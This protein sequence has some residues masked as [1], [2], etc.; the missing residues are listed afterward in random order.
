MCIVRVLDSETLKFCHTTPDNSIFSKEFE[1]IEA[2]INLNG[3]TSIFQDFTL[4]TPNH[5]VHN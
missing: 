3:T 1:K 2:Y 4:A 5:T